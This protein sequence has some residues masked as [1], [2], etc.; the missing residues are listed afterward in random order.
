[1]AAWEAADAIIAA[2]KGFALGLAAPKPERAF[3]I[4]FEAAPEAVPDESAED[5]V[6]VVAAVPVDAVKMIMKLKKEI[7]NNEESF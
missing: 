3:D 6:V 1:L 2:L 5:T 7:L 4:K